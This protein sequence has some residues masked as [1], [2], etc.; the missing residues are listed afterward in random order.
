MGVYI[1]LF[2]II[3]VASFIEISI[4]SIQSINICGLKVSIK[5]IIFFILYTFLLL[6]G[7]LRAE[8]LGVDVYNYKYLYFLR[9][10]SMDIEEILK[11]NVD[12][13]YAII[14]WLVAKLTDSFLV[15]RNLIYII[16]LSLY[17]A[18]IY[19]CSKY[20]SVSYLVYIGLL[21]LGM[22]FCILR[23]ALAISICLWAYYFAKIRKKFVFLIL[24]MLASTIHRTAIFFIVV[25][26]LIHTNFK[27]IKLAK[28]VFFVLL[29]GILSAF[30]MPKLIG[31]Y[32]I[33]DYSKSIVAG[34]GKKLLLFYI[35]VMAI[36]FCFYKYNKCR[37]IDISQEYDACMGIIYLQIGAI[38]FSLFTRMT[39]Y[40]SVILSVLVSNVLFCIKNKKIYLLIMA[41]LWGVLF[42][43]GL[44]SDSCHIVPYKSI[45][46]KRYIG[47]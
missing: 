26:L 1:S 21:F 34:E 3:V 30:F 17:S 7:L 47:F 16:T 33:N 23:Q 44:I 27:N 42:M 28:K 31:L 11:L 43:D 38:F 45:F 39:S 19:K 29:A 13:G 24:V 8:L 32:R 25:Y 18:Y 10:E 2:V 22:N 9:Y 15:F 35:I 20:I 4:K 40:I 41:L 37:I 5:K 36:I 12:C 46:E 6:I 14:N